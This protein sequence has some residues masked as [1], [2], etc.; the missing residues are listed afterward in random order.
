[1][2]SQEER[3][4]NVKADLLIMMVSLMVLVLAVLYEC[5]LLSLAFFMADEIECN[6]LWC[7]FSTTRQEIYQECY[8]NG[9]PVNCSGFPEAY[10]D[11]SQITV[12]SD[13]G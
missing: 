8:M 12:R 2:V 6:L 13:G 9:E 4:H 11:L 5:I 3:N 7:E 10:Y 1:M